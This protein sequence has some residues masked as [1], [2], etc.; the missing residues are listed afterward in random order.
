MKK[1]LT[2]MAWSSI[3]LPAVSLEQMLDIKDGTRTEPRIGCPHHIA[4][5]VYVITYQQRHVVLVPR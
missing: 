4:E 3:F 1:T 2:Q 5:F